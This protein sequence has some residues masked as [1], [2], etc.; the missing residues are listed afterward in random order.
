MR[1]RSHYLY[2]SFQLFT[3][4]YIR[5]RVTSYVQE[6][7]SDKIKL[8]Q[9]ESKDF[10]LPLHKLA[11][12]KVQLSY[13]VLL[14]LIYNTPPCPILCYVYH[15]LEYQIVSEYAISQEQC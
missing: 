7:R 13:T 10:F 5:M 15:N 2:V 12:F 9:R 6:S 1:K 14:T 8:Q 4:D 3:C 11:T